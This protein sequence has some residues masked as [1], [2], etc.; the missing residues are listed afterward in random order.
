L[1]TV[2]IDEIQA[3]VEKGATIFD[4]AQKA[5]ARRCLRHDLE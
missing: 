2:T 3:E 4:A 5:E 1:A